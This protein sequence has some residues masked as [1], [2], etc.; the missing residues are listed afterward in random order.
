MSQ[1]NPTYLGMRHFIDD[2]SPCRASTSWKQIRD[3]FISC[4]RVMCPKCRMVLKDRYGTRGTIS[5][6]YEPPTF[7]AEWAAKAFKDTHDK[8][9]YAEF[10]AVFGEPLIYR[11]PDVAPL[12]ET[13]DDDSAEEPPMV[14]TF[15]A[16][17]T[18]E[19]RKTFFERF[20]K[21]VV[22]SVEPIGDNG[23]LVDYDVV[24]G[25]LDAYRERHSF[26][27]LDI[28]PYLDNKGDTSQ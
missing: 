14:P 9:A 8:I 11:H 22:R 3:M 1:A 6:Y 10:V 5:T 26:A 17:M 7:G 28:N 16:N 18:D 20:A 21:T 25:K 23:V 13:E 27:A 12:V 24:T 15:L 19:E 4:S 2:N